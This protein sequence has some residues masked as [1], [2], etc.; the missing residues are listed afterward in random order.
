MMTGL[1]PTGKFHIGHMLL[2]QQMIFWQNLGAKIYIAVADVEA[3]NTRG[4][5]IEDSRKIAVEE[6]ILNY[7]ALGLKPEN[8]DIYF[9]SAR[10]DNAKKIKCILQACCNSSSARDFQ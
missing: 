10:S 9:Q 3:Y 7:I 1:M 5:S 4:Q 2:A 8:C 6:Y